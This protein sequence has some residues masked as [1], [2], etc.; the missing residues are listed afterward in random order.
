MK[1]DA[2]E[3]PTIKELFMDKMIDLILSGKLEA[4]EKLPTERELAESMRVSKTIVHLGLTELERR[5]CSKLC[6]K[7][8]AGD[9][10]RTASL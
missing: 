9:A 3:V 6:R 4:G 10:R 1:F 8:Y 5:F 7:G 2:I